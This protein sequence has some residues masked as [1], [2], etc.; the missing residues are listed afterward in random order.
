MI[1]E[2][3]KMELFS[4]TFCDT[5]EHLFEL[6]NVVMLATVPISKGRPIKLVER[7]KDR[8]DVKLLTVSSLYYYYFNYYGRKA[9]WLCQWNLC[10]LV[11]LQ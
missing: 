5:V 7:L 4:C 9:H 11:G 6:N 10:S 3:G 8:T 1:D 2:I